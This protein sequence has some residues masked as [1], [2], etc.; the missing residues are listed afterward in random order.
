MARKGEELF[1][2]LAREI[3]LSTPGNHRFSIQLSAKLESGRELRE[4]G[5]DPRALRHDGKLAWAAKHGLLAKRQYLNLGGY[6]LRG[7]AEYTSQAALHL[8]G[9]ERDLAATFS[10]H[11]E[12]LLPAMSSN[13]LQ[14]HSSLLRSSYAT[15]TVSVGGEPVT[16]GQLLEASPAPELKRLNSTWR[17]TLSGSSSG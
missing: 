12:L 14:S 8:P 7:Q 6:R 16:L 10:Y 13:L 11:A 9:T 15:V 2:D 4:R 17:S 1:G 5:E 3:H